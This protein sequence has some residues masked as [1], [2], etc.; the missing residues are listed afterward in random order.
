MATVTQ[1][2]LGTFCWP[3]LATSD[4]EGAKKFYTSMFG[5]TATD[6]DMGEGGT[7]T[8]LKLKGQDVAALYK[9][10]KDQQG[11]PPHWGPYV[12]V[13]S[14]DGTAAKA[15]QLGA[16]VIMEAFDVMEHGRMAVIQD[17]T[18]AIVSLW[19]A[20]K[21]IGAQVF[22]ETGALCWTELMTN[23][24]G[25]AESFYKQLFGWTTETMPMATG[26]TYIMF[27]KGD[28]YAGGMMK[29]APQMGPIPPNWGV[30]FQV[31]SVDEAA[32]KAEG[33]GAKIMVPPTDIPNMGRFSVIQDPQGAMVSVYHPLEQ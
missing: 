33:L 14:A 20:K 7:Y 18:G 2:V 23:D 30:Y 8:T 9:L 27:K 31:D 25:K 6:N 22:N 21:H 10:T 16:Q 11:V 5:W 1:Q 24:T 29:I 4:Q 28:T 32:K 12:A 26:A 15:K 13:E 19:Q 3:E 17:P